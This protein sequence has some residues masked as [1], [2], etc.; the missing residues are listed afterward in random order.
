MSITK[1]DIPEP[2]SSSDPEDIEFYE[3]QEADCIA[4]F[5]DAHESYCEAQLFEY[6]NRRPRPDI[7]ALTTEYFGP[8]IKKGKDNG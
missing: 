2:D 1:T 3:T 8:E 5:E 7:E 6:L 4:A